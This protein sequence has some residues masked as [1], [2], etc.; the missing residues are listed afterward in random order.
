MGIWTER[1]NLTSHVKNLT[2]DIIQTGANRLY[3]TFN[4][5][6]KNLVIDIKYK[7]YMK[8]LSNREQSIKS[9]RATESIHEWVPATMILADTKYKIK[10]K[11]KGVHKD[12][13]EHPTKW[14]F[15][16]KLLNNKSIDGVKRFSIQQPKTRNYL[17]EWL[18]MKV[19]EEESLIS[20]RTKFLETIVN[21][22]NLG[23]YFFEEQ[24]TKQ[25][26][27]NNKRREGPIIG[28]D[29]DLWIKEVNSFDNL[30][31][32][33]LEDT[34]WRAKIKPVQFDNDKIGT[35]QELYLKNAISLLEDFRKGKVK[36]DQ[37]FDLKQLATLM[38]IKAIFGSM[39]FDWRDI[40]FYYNP[41]TSL[42]EPIGREVHVGDNFNPE[43]AWWIKGNTTGFVF[44]KDQ[45]DFINL[46]YN[47]NDFYK[48]YLSELNRLTQD[49][50]LESI[51]NKNKSE[52]KFNKKILQLNFPLIDTF[53][54][55]HLEKV[56]RLIKQTLNPV[57]GINVYFIDYQNDNILLS[58]QNTQRL[59]IEIKS[60]RFNNG[61][62][63]NLNK[64]IVTRG[65]EHNKPLEN[66]IINVPCK[67]LENSKICEKFLNNKLITKNNK[68]IF[69]ILGQDNEMQSEIL[70][71]YSLGNIKTKNKEISAIKE[72][73]KISSIKI[74]NDI[75]EIT[76]NQ[77][78]IVIDKKIIIP[79]GYSLIF[80]AGTKIILENEGQIISYSPIFMN[81]EKEKPIIFTGD[82]YKNK[83]NK[84]GN[85]LTVINANSKSSI[86]NTIFKDLKSPLVGTG[87][88]L[89]GAINFYRSDIDLEN[90]NFSNNEGEDF[91][92]IISSNF[93]IKNIFI[94]E[95]D[96]DA[97]DIDFSNGTIEDATIVNSGNDALDFSRSKVNLKDIKINNAG[98]KGISAGEKSIIQ[99]KD[100]TI[101]NANIAIASKDLSE[102]EIENINIKNSNIAAAAYQK[103]SE[104]GPG[105][106][107]IDK[108]NISDTKELYLAQRDSLIKVNNNIINPTDKN[109][110]A[111]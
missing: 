40:K 47:D 37:T 57:Q 25:L 34:F 33:V 70:Q 84:Y 19:L 67:K 38:A 107:K 21:G 56:K 85:G 88:G 103:K 90:C 58:I 101:K 74:K 61:Q 22:E 17:Y 81:G 89:L 52:F 78:Q 94:N 80:N 72:L 91:L 39:E 108:I 96:Y 63:I 87:E 69:N 12:H 110:E 7:N 83:N 79:R 2:S 54:F 35:E 97:I 5:N 86:K 27:E 31:I 1:F 93:L 62:N 75:K 100:L 15:K 11:L 64:S 66:I 77:N 65:K 9:F 51:I 76:F 95:I 59:P 68:L 24:H 98:D 10:I 41:I 102:L 30:S 16:I 18:F 53:S 36:L 29:K 99:A 32:N 4:K 48:F 14:S 92:N 104:Y 82:L 105:V 8:I 60:V 71:F 50:Y 42:L 44:S 49:G 106:I 109:Y 13:W 23:I 73:E 46:F 6:K 45:K 111:Y 55:E 20:H 26:I 3:S 28:L 43:T